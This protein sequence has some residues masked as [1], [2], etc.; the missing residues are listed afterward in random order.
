MVNKFS[1]TLEDV[2]VKLL[3]FYSQHKLIYISYV[4]KGNISDISGMI[5]NI[6]FVKKEIIMI[7]SKK[8][9]FLNILNIN[10]IS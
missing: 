9:P 2:G 8:I 1:K 3:K 10:E 5:E 7:P 4:E 6:D